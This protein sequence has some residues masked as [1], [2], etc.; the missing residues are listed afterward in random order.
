MFCVFLYFS[1]ALDVGAKDV[2]MAMQIACVEAIA[3]LARPKRM[4]WSPMHTS[5]KNS[6]LVPNIFCL[7]RLTRV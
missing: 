7:S 5:V 4:T 1:G 6:V 3:G 2:N